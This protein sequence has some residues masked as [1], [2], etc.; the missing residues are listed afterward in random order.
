LNPFSKR[1]WKKS[2]WKAIYNPEKAG[3]GWLI[4]GEI[5]MDAILAVTLKGS[6]GINL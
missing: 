5:L 1:D 3:S 2:A 6:L 4:G